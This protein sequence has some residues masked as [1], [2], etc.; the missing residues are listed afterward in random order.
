ML[1]K[2][3]GFTL[4]EVMI[5]VVIL[6]IISAIAIPSYQD[7]L[8]RSNR[9]DAKNAL[10]LIA[11]EQ[12]RFFAINRTYTTD[13][14]N[15][16]LDDTATAASAVSASGHFKLSVAAGASGNIASSYKI[17]ADTNTG[18]QGADDCKQFTLDS[19][20]VKTATKPICWD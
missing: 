16:S 10:N 20:G 3:K 2:N 15:F 8:R 18:F 1:I 7:M 14:T 5:V 19:A 11:N 17:K 6:G 13:M 12:A 9:T 4:M